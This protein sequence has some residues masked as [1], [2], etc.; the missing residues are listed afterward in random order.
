ML[1]E[2]KKSKNANTSDIDRSLNNIRNKYKSSKI[3]RKQKGLR[4]GKS[5]DA[6][7]DLKLG[8]IVIIEGIN[9][10]A[11]VISEPDNK[12]NIK[13]QMGILKMDSNI[14]NVTKIEGDSKTEKNI[15]KVYNAKKKQ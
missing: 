2:A 4:I 14:K 11:E 13:L 6:P 5:D 1:K 8:D 3:E 12:G 9:E 15:Q 10:R 7:E